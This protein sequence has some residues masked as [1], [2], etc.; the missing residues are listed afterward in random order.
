MTKRRARPRMLMAD[1]LLKDEAAPGTV[2]VVG[3]GVEV[4]P[5]S[6]AGGAVV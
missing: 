6:D 2:L 1:R 4:G 3:S 5:V